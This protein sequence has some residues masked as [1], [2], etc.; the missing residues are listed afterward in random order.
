MKFNVDECYIIHVKH[1][2]NPLLM[3]SKMSGRQLEVTVS[4]IYLGIGINNKLNWA[5]HISNKASMTNKVLG[6][7]LRSLHS[8]S[9][10]VN[11]TAYKSL[12]RP[13]LEY[14]SCTLDPYHQE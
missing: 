4:H 13:K 8:C 2:R 14:C 3:T 5:E 7:L 11:E 1:K 12:V 6:L 9:P 10:F